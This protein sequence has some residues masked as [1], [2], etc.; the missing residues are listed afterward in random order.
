LYTHFHFLGFFS[1]SKFNPSRENCCSFYEWT[2]F[3]S[4]Y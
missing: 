2:N 1:L 3:L 4:S